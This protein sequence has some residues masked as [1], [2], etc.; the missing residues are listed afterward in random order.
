MRFIVLAMLMIFAVGAE[1]EK[2]D[3]GVKYHKVMVKKILRNKDVEEY[4]VTFE[5]HNGRIYL[6]GDIIVGDADDF[7]KK[8][9]VFKDFIIADLSGSTSGSMTGPSWPQSIVPYVISPS[10]TSQEIAVLTERLA[11]MESKF[12]VDFVPRSNQSN[13]IYFTYTPA[14]DFAAGRS[15]LGMVGGKQDI[16]LSKAY[17]F[18]DRTIIHEALH[19]LGYH[20]EH[21]RSDRDSYITVNWSNLDNC[22]SS[23]EKDG[24]ISLSRPYDLYSIMH[25]F[26]KASG[27]CV[28]D[29]NQPMFTVNSN[30]ALELDNIA[31]STAD[32]DKLVQDYGYGKGTSLHWFSQRCLADGELSW[33]PVNNAVSYKVEYDTYGNGNWL[34]WTTTTN[35]S[36]S[37]LGGNGLPHSANVRVVGINSQGQQSAKSNPEYVKYYE[38]CL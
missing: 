37:F 33:T 31:M 24:S 4:E 12:G 29:S 16:E 35:T 25:Y 30:P 20:H 13:Y 32:I 17:G 9:G 5:E 8:R 2:I 15:K 36:L 14:G 27:S 3:K 11:Y 28:F 7:Y 6:G 26:S 34:T 38:V 23:F 10:Y 1:A 22:T 18:N 21:Q 19:A